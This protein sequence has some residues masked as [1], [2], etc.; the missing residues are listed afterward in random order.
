W[1]CGTGPVPD[2]PRLLSDVHAEGSA[3]VQGRRRQ[4]ARDRLAGPVRRT[5]RPARGGLRRLASV[6]QATE[7][8]V[9]LGTGSACYRAGTAQR[10]VGRPTGPRRIAVVVDRSSS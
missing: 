7:A 8:A 5:D 10:G 4:A 1:A 9:E 3:R 6:Q 2:D